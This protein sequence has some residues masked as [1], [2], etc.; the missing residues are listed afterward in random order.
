MSPSKNQS[1]LPANRLL[2]ALPKSE[3]RR[4]LP[5]LTDVTLDFGETLYERGDII[6]FVYFPNNSIISLLSTVAVRSTLEVGMVGNEGMVGL[7]LFMGIDKASTRALVQGGGSAFR[8]K[9]AAFRK[10]SSHTSSM[11]L[12]LHRYTHSLLTQISQSSAC[13]RFHTAD[14]RLARWLLMTS[15]RMA[16]N[17]FRVTQDFLA[18]MVGV[19]REAVNKVTG[20]LQKANLVKYSRG[21]FAILDRPGLETLTCPCYAIIRESDDFLN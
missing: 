6:S 18:N 19:R 15:D 10:F 2:N 3:Y 21:A 12:L 8:M 11:H 9:S 16:S 14:A 20:A 1:V 13:N 4:L 17:E 7:S 5:E